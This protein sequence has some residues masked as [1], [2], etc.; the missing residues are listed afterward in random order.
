[1][2]ED[3]GTGRISEELSVLDRTSTIQTIY[4]DI[5]DLDLAD[6]IT[7]NISY[8]NWGAELEEGE[9]REQCSVG[10]TIEF[11]ITRFLSDLHNRLSI[12]KENSTTEYISFLRI[13][14]DWIKAAQCLIVSIPYILILLR[15][16]GVIHL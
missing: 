14:Q 8:Y 5:S 12:P 3:G 9:N 15:R 6:T 4:Y 11:R 7:L 2:V 10:Y 16:M 13:I 1:M